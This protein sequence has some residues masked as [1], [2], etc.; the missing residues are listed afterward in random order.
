MEFSTKKAKLRRERLRTILEKARLIDERAEAHS[1]AVVD[2][3]AAAQEI[4][5]IVTDLLVED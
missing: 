5:T 4:R 1:D 2:V 3:R